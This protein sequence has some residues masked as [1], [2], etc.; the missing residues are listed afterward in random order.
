[1]NSGNTTAPKPPKIP[2]WVVGVVIVGIVVAILLS[3]FFSN[4][5]CPAWGFQCT[6]MRM[7]PG[8]DNIPSQP[9]PPPVPHAP[10]PFSGSSPAPITVPGPTPS[11][12]PTPRA[13]PSPS[14][15]AN[16]CPS[17]FMQGYS[18]SGTDWASLAYLPSDICWKATGS[19][20][21]PSGTE[22]IDIA[23]PPMR[24]CYTSPNPP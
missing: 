20:Q 19:G 3:I 23:I 4:V 8:V 6:S 21:C 17:G 24:L 11:P 10:V 13:T 1:M 2:G 14:P 7:D 22:S 18:G 15:V 9:P 16:P 12:G 5:A